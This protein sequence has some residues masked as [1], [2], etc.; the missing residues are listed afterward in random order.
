MSPAQLAQTNQLT[1]L[2]SE[3]LGTGG[4]EWVPACV[5]GCDLSE[6]GV[7]LSGESVPDKLSLLHQPCNHCQGGRNRHPRGW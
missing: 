6:E 4:L 3:A 7:G 1:S 2:G 5:R